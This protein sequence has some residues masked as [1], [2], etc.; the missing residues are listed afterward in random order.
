MSSMIM[1]RHPVT[2]RVQRAYYGFCWTGF[3]WGGVPALM[4]GNIPLGLGMLA[5]F[6]L[7]F[8][9]GNIFYRSLAI[10]LYIFAAIALGLEY[11]RFHTLRLIDAGFQFFDRAERVAVAKR[12]L[13]ITQENV[14]NI[15]LGS[16]G[17]GT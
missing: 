13:R 5:L 11:N 3:F 6:V 15:A 17:R 1:M 4:R 8:L 12:A 10:F 2:N 9:L 16:T 7:P 14:G